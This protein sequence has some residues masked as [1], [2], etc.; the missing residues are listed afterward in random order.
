MIR[1]REKMKESKKDGRG[2]CSTIRKI[3]TEDEEK[4]E[5]EGMQRE[6]TERRIEDLT[7]DK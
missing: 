6:K 7:Q 5:R 3:M 4:T 1:I 2:S